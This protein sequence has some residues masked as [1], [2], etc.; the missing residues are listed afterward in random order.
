MGHTEISMSTEVYQ[1]YNHRVKI[2]NSTIS[3]F[4]IYFNN[5]LLRNELLQISV[6]LILMNL[7]RHARRHV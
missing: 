4:Q 7:I 2:S 3:D 6:A 5:S 1:K